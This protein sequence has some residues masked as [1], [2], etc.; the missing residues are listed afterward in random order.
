MINDVGQDIRY[1]DGRN[2]DHKRDIIIKG[3]TYICYCVNCGKIFDVY[4]NEK[5]TLTTL[6][7]MTSGIGNNDNF[8]LN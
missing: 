1:L 6:G 3:E 5:D 2:C 4:K 8:T 7:D